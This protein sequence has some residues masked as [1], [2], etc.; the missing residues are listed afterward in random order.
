MCVHGRRGTHHEHGGVRLILD[1]VVTCYFDHVV[2][3][4]RLLGSLCTKPVD[5]LE[6]GGGRERVGVGG[7]KGEGE[8]GRGEGTE[9]GRERMGA[10]FTALPGTMYM[11]LYSYSHAQ[12][13]RA[14]GSCT[15]SRV[16]YLGVDSAG[17]V[18]PGL[19]DKWLP[20]LIL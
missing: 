3:Y 8:R 19:L 2:L 4:Q 14:V 5:H 13:M 20:K 7:G 15:A 16:A 10:M 9:R 1:V 6:G 18:G 12:Y 11:Y 17:Q